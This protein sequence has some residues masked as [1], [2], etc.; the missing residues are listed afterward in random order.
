MTGLNADAAYY[1]Y[2]HLQFSCFGDNANKAWSQELLDTFDVS[3]DKLPR[4]VSPFEVVGKTTRA[5]TTQSG[6]AAGVPVVA[7]CGD[8]SASTF[9]CTL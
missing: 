8:T 9:G 4:I 7:G 1:D 2:T 5:F 6:V 3:A